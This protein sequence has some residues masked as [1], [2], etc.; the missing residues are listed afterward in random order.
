M[1]T[2][3]TSDDERQTSSP[4]RV[5]SGS[6]PAAPDGADAATRHAPASVPVGGR[7]VDGDGD[8]AGM[9]TQTS[10]T[11]T[12]PLPAGDIA[13]RI[14][15]TALPPRRPTGDPGRWRAAL[16]VSTGI[17]VALTSF[18]AGMLAE[19]D[20]LGT[21]STS[22]DSDAFGRVAEVG[23]LLEDEY[24]FRPDDPAERDAFRQ[25][26]VDDA[27]SGMTQGLHEQDPYTDYLPPVEAGPAAAQLAGQYEGIGVTIQPVAGQLTVIAPFPGGPAER[28]GIRA[29]DILEA[30]D[31]RPLADLGDGEAAQY[32]SGPAGTTVRLT[33]RRPG[34]AEPFEI[35]V[36]R[37]TIVQQQVVYGWLPDWRMAHIRITVFG[38]QTT[39]QLDAA[40]DRAAADGAVGIVLDLRGNG[41]G[42]VTAAQETIGRFVPADR[43]PALF[44]RSDATTGEQRPEPILAGPTAAHD[45]PLVVLV[46]AGTASAAEIVAGALRDYD[47]AMLVGEETFGKGSVQRVHTFDDGASARI[48][49]AEWLTPSGQ[50]IPESGLTVD[51]RL[52]QPPDPEAGPD[53]QLSAASRVLSTGGWSEVTPRW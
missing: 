48:T 44:E 23:R 49:I 9:P 37:E 29:G 11:A 39:P 18:A 22:A 50:H 31:G 45:T 28:A 41:G 17:L 24:Y 19:R 52:A 5:S 40:L 42:W 27:L 43:G 3:S 12:R 15:G 33:V 4:S 32:V 8:L 53:P 21:G 1:V 36:T 51:H 38:D 13:D 46:N 16:V 6:D 26:L 14:E 10:V 20:L 2:P 35:L 34:V 25:R 7:A 30:A 47:R